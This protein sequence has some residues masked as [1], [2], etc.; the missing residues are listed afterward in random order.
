MNKN[1]NKKAKI[2]ELNKLEEEVKEYYDNLITNQNNV[3]R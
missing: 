3:K 1:I 2:N